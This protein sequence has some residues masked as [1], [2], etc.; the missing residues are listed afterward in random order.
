MK[1][2]ILMVLIGL[3]FT[4]HAAFDPFPVGVPTIMTSDTN[5]TSPDGFFYLDSK[6]PVVLWQTLVNTNML[7]DAPVLFTGTTPSICGLR[8]EQR[9]MSPRIVS[10]MHHL[11]ME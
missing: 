11:L 6:M 2:M 9:S 3:M 10:D 5:R 1:K 7:L 8:I 4:A